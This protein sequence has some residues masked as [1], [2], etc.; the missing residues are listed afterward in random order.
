[1]NRACTFM[2]FLAALSGVAYARLPERVLHFPSERPVG[3]ILIQDED[4]L[5]PEV[6]A[7][8]HPGYAYA[9]SEFLGLAQGD[10]RIPAGQRVLLTLGGTGATRRQCLA[11]LNSLDPNAVYRLL[12]LPP[13]HLDDGLMPAVVRLT[14]L[15]VL[16]LNYARI[17]PKGAAM[18]SQLPAL[19]RLDT[20]E[21]MSDAVMAQIADV[22]SLKALNVSPSRMTD[23][24]LTSIATLRSLEVLHLEGN[25]KM[26]NDSLKALT[27]LPSLRHLRILGP[28]TDRAMT[29]LAAMPALR[30]L[31]L[32]TTNVTDAGLQRLSQSKTIERL[33]LHWLD[34]ITDRGVAHLRNMPQL[35]G[36]DIQ[37]AGLSDASLELLATM[38]NLDYLHL[39]N[40]GLT[41]AGVARLGQ[42]TGLK[43]LWIDCASNSP[44]TDESLRV[45]GGLHR[46]EELHVTGTGFT[47][48]G[49]EHL[50]DLKVLRLLS[51]SAP[52]LDNSYLPTFA[53]LKSLR[54]LSWSFH[55][56]ATL[57]GLKALN[58]L[59]NLEDLD[60][61]QVR[62]DNGGLDLSGLKNLKNLMLG[63]CVQAKIGDKY[64][65]V[66]DAWQDSDLASL[67]GLTNLEWLSLSGPGIGDEGVKY[68][69]PL[70][71]LE[72]LSVEGSPNLTD[73]ALKYLAGIRKLRSL[74]IYNSRITE[75]GLAHLYPLKGL[76]SVRIKTTSSISRPAMARLETELPSLRTLELSPPA[77]RK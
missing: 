62:Q 14:G 3:S 59:P 45:I 68:L 28:F 34:K 47:A 15:R 32:D 52:D 71:N 77:P 9:E 61:R 13:I 63:M 43:Y 54:R 20:P 39:P 65:R 30:V 10:V 70:V 41:D 75:E 50:S 38:P 22:Q 8:F 48:K 72:I 31:W 58:G 18:L 12:F 66:Y 53:D 24:G 56:N 36:L 73:K 6:T 76:N 46:L 2:A 29:H 67:S 27:Q 25:D 23:A 69:A 74:D 17:T 21:Q 4:L 26:S 40:E 7:G 49:I 44:L 5:I 19:E 16:W 55:N 37:H 11:V 60:A 33:N 35:K 42:L 1:V 64:I 51:F 57:S